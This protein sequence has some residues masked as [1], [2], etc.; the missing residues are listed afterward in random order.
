MRGGSGT[1]RDG[2]RCVWSEVGVVLLRSKLEACCGK[3]KNL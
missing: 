1:H 2:S 3:C